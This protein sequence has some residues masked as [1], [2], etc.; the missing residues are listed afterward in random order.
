MEKEELT[1]FDPAQLLQTDEARDLFRED[2]LES[3]NMG[4]IESSTSVLDR[5]RIMGKTVSV[6]NSE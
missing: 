4:Y 3:G 2:A 5:A 1:H 6:K